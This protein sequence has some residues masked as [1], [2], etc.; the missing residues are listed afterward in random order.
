M[1][2]LIMKDDDENNKR[3]NEKKSNCREKNK[4]YAIYCDACHRLA[5]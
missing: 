4:R 5:R 3:K 2:I 1:G